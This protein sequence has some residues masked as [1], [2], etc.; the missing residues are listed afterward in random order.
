VGDV[1]EIKIVRHEIG[2]NLLFLDLCSTPCKVLVAFP[3]RVVVLDA[4]KISLAS[5]TPRLI[6]PAPHLSVNLQFL[7]DAPYSL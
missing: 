7:L 3:N 5:G 2:Q 6:A 4:H 1:V